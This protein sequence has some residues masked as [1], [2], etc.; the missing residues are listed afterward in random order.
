LDLETR[1]TVDLKRAGAARYFEDP[2]TEIIVAC[3]ALNDDPVQTWWP[4]Q[5][6]PEVIFDQVFSGGIISGWNVGGFEKIGWDKVLGPRHGWPVPTLRQY[7]D[8]A[9]AAAAMGLPR[10]LGDAARALGSTAQKDA[11]GHRLMLQMC[12]P[13]KARKGEAPGIYW[14]EDQDRLDRLAAYCASDVETERAVKKQLVPLS[15]EEVATWR[16]DWTMNDRGVLLDLPLVHAMQKIAIEATADLDAE[17][18]E[19]SG[20]EKTTQVARLSAWITEAGVECTSLA[21]AEIERMLAI[22][23]LPNS[24]RAA[25][26]I[27]RD[28]AK[29]ST[30]KLKAMLACVSADGRARGQHLY[31]GAGTGRWSG[32][33]IQVQNFPR[34][35]G[36]VKDPEAAVDDFLTGDAEVIRVRHGKP[37]NAVSDMLRSCMMAA[38][39][40]RL[41]AA[42]FSAIEG[43]VTAWLAGEVWKIRAFEEADAGTGPGIY[44]LTAAGILGKNV[45]T[46]TK[47]ERQAYGKIPELAL[48]FQGGVQAFDSMAKI[49]RVN[50]DDAYEPLAANTEPKV[51]ARALKRYEE[52]LERN[53][54]GT[55]TMTREAWIA[56]EVTKVLWREKHPATKALWKGLEEAAFDATLRPG[57][58]FSYRQI[59]YVVK[60]GFLWCR[61]PSGRC[62]AYGSPRI[63]ERATPW[64]ERKAVVTC[65][66]VDSVTKRWV[67]FAL[68]GG[69]AVENAVQAAAR[70]CM[71]DGMLA[72]EA[73]GYPIVLTVHDEAVA[74]VDEGFG[75]LEEFERLLAHKLPWAEGL[76][77]VAT[78]YE[79]HRYRK[80]G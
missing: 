26:E 48:G 74:E 6:C 32:R 25:L 4:G 72:C 5:P 71:R 75:S 58:V 33:L 67:R 79:A 1:S 30:K 15:P 65:L 38:P 80:D 20:V 59:S 70:D 55:D 78:G 57:T 9:A 34:G 63:Q 31:H 43:R 35:T 44:E 7:D 22:P 29:T 3:Y 27:R 23:D 8:T 42:D 10:A 11:A 76:P 62:L 50:M 28:G 61:L 53:D 19:V 73:A 52:C 17:L 64:G 49:Y 54:T 66:G 46:I 37:M 41:L 39:G 56:S 13:R 2:T 47:A 36:T 18:E 12:K 60:R 40:K 16:F 77:V 21:K 45:A 68:Y 69:L 14:W 51:W 24:V